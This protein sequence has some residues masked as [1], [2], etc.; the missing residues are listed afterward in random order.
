MAAYGIDVNGNF[1]V[2]PKFVSKENYKISKENKDDE[3]FQHST[4]ETTTKF[5]NPK[6]KSTTDFDDGLIW[7]L[8]ACLLFIIICLTAILI[9]LLISLKKRR[10]K[11]CSSYEIFKQTGSTNSY[12]GFKDTNKVFLTT[13]NHLS[14]LVP[15]DKP[16]HNLETKSVIKLHSKSSIASS[17]VERYKQKVRESLWLKT[18]Q[19]Q[20][21][22][23][24]QTTIIR[25]SV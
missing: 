25:D 20:T 8:N 13:S 12:S 5:S 4:L 23:V 22:G 14:V 15:E 9:Y 18:K 17:V 1:K 2:Q 10:E 19:T 3:N 16:S 6:Y 7:G 24:D 21:P 11:E